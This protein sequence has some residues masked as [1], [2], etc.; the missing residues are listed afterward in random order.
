MLF[1][2]LLSRLNQS[3]ES[4]QKDLASR[5]TAERAQ[6]K[7]IGL[8]VTSMERN[9]QQKV[10][11]LLIK[12]GN[13]TIQTSYVS[14]QENEKQQLTQIAEELMKGLRSPEDS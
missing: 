11:L 14:Y 9:L 1:I 3:Y 2:P 7:T 6:T 12:P 8:Q 5:I 10:K 13:I 4:L